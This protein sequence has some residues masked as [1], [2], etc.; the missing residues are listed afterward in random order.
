MAKKASPKNA[1]PEK[2]ASAGRGKRENVIQRVAEE[3]ET[4][5]LEGAEMATETTSAETNV[6]LAALAAIEGPRDSKSK[7]EATPRDAKRKNA[8]SKKR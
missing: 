5:F 3:V 7:A 2:P 6:V 1:G 8:R 4:R